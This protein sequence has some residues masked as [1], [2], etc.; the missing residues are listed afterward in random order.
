[1]VAQRFSMSVMVIHHTGSDSQS[2][3]SIFTSDASCHVLRIIHGVWIDSWIYW[4]LETRMYVLTG[5]QP[6]QLPTRC[7]LPNCCR[8]WP[9][10]WFL[11]PSPTGSWYNFTLW[12]LWE[13]RRLFRLT[14]QCQRYFTTDGLPS[15]SSS[16]RQAPL[17]SRPAFF[18]TEHLFSLCNILSDEMM[19]LSFTIVVGPRQRSYSQVR[20]LR[21]SWPHF[22][23]PYSRPPPP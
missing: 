11:V 9:A 12:Q 10:Q 13:P 5:N 4:T 17:D 21:D 1:M 8:S 19:G 3:Q 7:R 18:P 16:L 15:I 14:S 6:L 22:T 20:V 23:D 2:N